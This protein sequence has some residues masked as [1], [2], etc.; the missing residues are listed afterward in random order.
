M[1]FKR[2][3]SL[4]TST[5][6]LGRVFSDGLRRSIRCGRAWIREGLQDARYGR[7][8][9]LGLM[10]I[11]HSETQRRHAVRWI[12]SLRKDY[13]LTAPSPWLTFDAIDFIER[14]MNGASI[15]FEYGCGGSTLFW[16]AR[17]AHCTSAEHDP[18]WAERVKAVLLS[19]GRMNWELRLVEPTPDTSSV[20]ADPAD[21]EGYVSS[22][23]AYRGLSFRDYAASIDTYPDRYFD[24]VVVDGRARPSCAKH[25]ARKVKTHGLLVL[26]NAERPSYASVER[27]LRGKGWIRRDFYGAGPSLSY[28]WLTYVWERQT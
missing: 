24:L 20:V 6:Q 5:R 2:K 4:R 28:F 22:D 27:D 14:R 23:E 8:L 3:D 12:Q 15:I 18:D 26:D 11:L 9:R 1:E 17:G 21:P 10:A 19:T 16:V 13:L 7:S 25:A